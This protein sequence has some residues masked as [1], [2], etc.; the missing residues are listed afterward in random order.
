MRQLKSTLLAT[1]LF[2]A[3]FAG[4]AQ[5]IEATPPPPPAPGQN[6]DPVLAGT[7]QFAKGAKGANEINMDGKSL[8][9]LGKGDAGKKLDFVIVRNYEYDHAGMYRQ[10]DVD[11]IT[12]RLRDGSWSCIVHTHSEKESADICMRQ[13]S[14][15][16]TN[17]I[18][19]I[20]AEPKELSFIHVKGRM[21]IQD[22]QNMGA[23]FGAPATPAPPTPPLTK[24]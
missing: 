21:S 19:V 11:A 15:H 23:N 20:A 10:A 1:L 14:D 16:E 22:L 12:A 3:T 17:E 6:N 7:E 13:G 4:R 5:T 18:I 2:T 9:L 8:S 24:R